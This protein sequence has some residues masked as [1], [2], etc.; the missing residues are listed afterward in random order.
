MK[1]FNMAQK[2][3]IHYIK[4]YKQKEEKFLKTYWHTSRFGRGRI[5]TAF[6]TRSEVHNV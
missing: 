4:Q 5:A 1:V 6:Y 2:F 3:H